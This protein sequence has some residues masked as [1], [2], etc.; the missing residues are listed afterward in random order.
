MITRSLGIFFALALASPSTSVAATILTGKISSAQKQV[1]VAP[2][3]SRWQIQIQWMAAE[4]SIVNEGDL[5]V[6]FDGANEQARLEQNEESLARLLLEFEQLKLAQDQ[7]VLEAEGRLTLAKMRV[8]KAK[9]EAS[10]P[11]SE[12]SKYDKG[13]Y[14][15]ALERAMLEQVKAQEAF[16]RAQKERATE[17]NKKDVD[18]L[19]TKEEMV[20]LQDLLTKLRVKAEFTGPVNYAMHPWSG[21]KLASGNNVQPSWNIL[22]LQA[23]NNFQI[24]TWIHEVDAVNI[25]QGDS[26]KIVIDAYPQQ[27][28]QG[29]I[30]IL[31]TQTEKKPLWGKS[32][33]YPATIVFI[34]QPELSI[35]PGMSVR[36]EPNEV[37]N[38][39]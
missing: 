27:A 4:G 21:N 31:S 30:E 22:D 37:T 36:L 29:R 6:V 15:L 23:N 32:A 10:V 5:L 34:E 14:E 18:I 16:D 11:A 7:R 24:E 3:A 1:V 8:E 26:V 38:N 20:Y 2:R 28:F 13:Q 9:I 33:Y 25:E 39:G 35:V 19:K 17:L 12:V